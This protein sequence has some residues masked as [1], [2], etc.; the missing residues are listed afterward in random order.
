MN[1]PISSNLQHISA[2]TNV[3]GL[4]QQPKQAH[5]GRLLVNPKLFGQCGGEACRMY[6]P[7]FALALPGLPMCVLYVAI[8]S[9]TWLGEKLHLL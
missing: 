4:N 1:F 8:S 5:V 3:V 7:L 6:V 2:C 9:L